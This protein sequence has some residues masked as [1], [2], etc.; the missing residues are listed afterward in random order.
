MTKAKR[1]R[2]DSRGAVAAKTV[3]FR[4]RY[5]DLEER[6]RSLHARLALFNETAQRSPVYQ[7]AKKLLNQRFRAASIAQRGSV[8][9]AA[10]WLIDL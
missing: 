6:R 8:L 10:G 5:D 1:V 9:D 7:N 4:A 2:Y 3:S